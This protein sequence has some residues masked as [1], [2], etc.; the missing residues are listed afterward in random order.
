MDTS[1][2]IENFVRSSNRELKEFLNTQHSKKDI[3]IFQLRRR[4]YIE[5]EVF[6]YF[7]PFCML[8]SVVMTAILF[9]KHSYWHFHKRAI[10]RD[11]PYAQLLR[12][13]Y[14]ERFPGTWKAK[15]YQQINDELDAKYTSN[16]RIMSIN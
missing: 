8:N 15:K 6:T 13:S 5:E 14:I 2:K 1:A 11:K 9:R 12:D 10:S 3:K 16:L 7:Y 4:T